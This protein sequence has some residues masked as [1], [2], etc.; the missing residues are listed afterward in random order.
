MSSAS[1]SASIVAPAASAISESAGAIP[2]SPSRRSVRDEP[3]TTS[4]STSSDV[5]AALPPTAGR[6]RTSS[7]ALRMRGPAPTASPTSQPPGR[8]ASTRIE[9]AS[10]ARAGSCA[11]ESSR[12]RPTS[13][14]TTAESV[15]SPVAGAASGSPMR[16]PTLRC[17]GAGRVVLETAAIRPASCAVS[18]PTRPPPTAEPSARPGTASAVP[19][20]SGANAPSVNE[21]ATSSSAASSRSSTVCSGCA[22]DPSDR[23]A[24]TASASAGSVSGEGALPSWAVPTVAIARMTSGRF[25]AA[26]RAAIPAVECATRMTRA[27]PVSVTIRSTTVAI[28]VASAATSPRPSS[29]RSAV[30]CWATA[31][32]ESAPAPPRRSKC[33]PAGRF[34]STAASRADHTE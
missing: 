19:A 31:V 28:C 4:R 32:T 33:A 9:A 23:A 16:A 10:G 26:S 25:A 22:T 12:T 7:S 2:L 13:S 17:V 14:R 21:P 6:T 27:R 18:A 34:G 24:R 3:R 5:A 29:A 20:G 15:G 1:V 8:P 30:K 11:E